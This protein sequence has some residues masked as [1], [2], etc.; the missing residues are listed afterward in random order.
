LFDA[1]ARSKGYTSRMLSL[2]ATGENFQHAV[3]EIY[4]PQ[5]GKWVL[6]DCDFNLA[7][8]RRGQWLN[9]RELQ[10]TW[11]AWKSQA[12]MLPNYGADDDVLHDE[13]CRQLAARLELE[14]VEL[15]PAGSEMRASNLEHGSAT[16][17]NLELFAHVFYPARNNYLSDEYP[18]GHPAGVR[19]YRLSATPT[20]QWLPVCPEA[21]PLACA[22]SMYW[23]VGACEVRGEVLPATEPTLALSFFTYTPNFTRFETARGDADDW[24]EVAGNSLELPLAADEIV[25]RVRTKNAAGLAG[26]VTTL[27]VNDEPAA[28]DE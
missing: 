25:L 16:R 12:A 23:S 28:V 9:A 18:K 6:I 21:I 17:R 26:Q 11:I 2:S 14:V 7:Y 1:A 24:T 27:R 10:E 5:Q 13:A 3:S 4:L 22:D 15:G 19:M 8:R 20:D